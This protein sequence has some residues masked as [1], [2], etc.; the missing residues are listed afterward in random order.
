MGNLTRIILSLGGG[1]G[2][3]LL[4][5]HHLSHGLQ[6]LNGERLRKF[7]TAATGNRFAGIATGAVSTIIVQSSSIIAV[8]LIGFVSSGL[9]SLG[10]TLPVLIGANAGTTFT[11]WLMAF[12]P[13]PEILGLA[14]LALGCAFYLLPF[15]TKWRFGGQAMV[16]LGLVFL[17]MSLMKDGVAPIR[18]SQRMLAAL[19]SLNA[20]GLGSAALVALAA[21]LFTAVIQ[22]SAAAIIIFMTLAAEGVITYETCICALFGA[23][24]GTTMT[25][26][27]A[28][29]GGTAAAK[30]TALL[31]TA[32]NAFGSIVLLP[33][34]LPVFAPLGRALFP[35]A[36]APEN[37]TTF[38]IMLPVAATDTLF[39]VLRGVLVYPLSAFWVKF[40]ERAI[41]VKEEEKPHLSS[42]NARA[43][44]SGIIACE[45]AMGEILFMG[46]S[47]LDI[48]ESVR[49]LITGDGGEKT[50]NHI[51]HREAVLDNIQREI[52]EFIGKILTSRL[53]SATAM[54]ARKILRLAD[55][56]ESLS[57]KGPKIVRALDRLHDEGAK[58][59][60]FAKSQMLD[61]HDRAMEL[62]AA[63][64]ANP[65]MNAQNDEA[66]RLAADLKA[67][68]AA[69]RETQIVRIGSDDSAS[70]GAILAALD[71]LNAYARIRSIAMNLVEV[72]KP[73][74][75]LV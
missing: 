25:G 8:M 66:R 9:M 14:L 62:M 10:E 11:V 68:L 56:L 20:T 38:G 59:S 46:E 42:L 40:V 65:Q 37:G 21:A 69:A 58:L 60:G 54:R 49:E 19:Q 39:A 74:R 75:F 6:S 4:G 52:T 1:L 72:G 41:P 33:L 26:W 23:N 2:A 44:Q 34:A 45:Q 3:F 12:A 27:I 36:F 48:M 5:M 73:G 47:V 17:G 43:A 71:M 55:E 70:N 22:S 53:E 57:D 18:E 30:R 28:A 16:G 50:R 63:A 67:R 7:M 24:I 35:S 13:S 51:F 29:L 32:T 15:Q 61:I 64:V 31:H